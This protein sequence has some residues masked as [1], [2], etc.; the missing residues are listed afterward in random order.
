MV[1]RIRN[2]EN[3][4]K[5]H[6]KHIYQLLAKEKQI[7]HWKVSVGYG[8]LQLVVGLSILSTGPLGL[9]P[10]LILLVIYFLGFVWANYIVRVRI[11]DGS[12][13]RGI[14]NN[15][16]AP[17]WHSFLF[18]R[19][20]EQKIIG[21]QCLYLLASSLNAIGQ[22]KMTR[23]NSRYS[24]VFIEGFPPEGVAIESQGHLL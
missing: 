1:V 17:F 3:L 6:R 21:I 12:G 4:L 5:V 8:I 24:N 10:V 15:V 9:L 2:G 16:S 22:L 13:G 23:D 14:V 11:A 19:S 18:R 20:P 7:A